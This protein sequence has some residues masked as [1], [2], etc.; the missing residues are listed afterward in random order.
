MSKQHRLYRRN[1]PKCRVQKKTMYDTER[2]ASFAMFRA[3]SHDP[4]MDIHD[5]HTYTC[6]RCGKWHFGHISYYKKYLENT[7]V[8]QSPTQ[9]G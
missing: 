4:N 6:D 8:S 9:D 2:E 1:R 5:M 3:W 7:S